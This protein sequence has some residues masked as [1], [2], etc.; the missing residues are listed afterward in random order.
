MPQAGLS[1]SFRKLES[2]VAAGELSLT[3][4]LG[5]ARGGTTAFEKHIFRQLSFDANVNEPSLLGRPP[6]EAASEAPPAWSSRE[7]ATFAQVLDTV[8]P[9]DAAARRQGRDLVRAPVR[10]IVKEVTNKVLPDM[11]PLWCRLAHT[12]L[13]V[14]RNPSLQ[15]ESRLKSIV[16][17]IGSGALAQWGVTGDL[18][19]GDH[20]E[21]LVH[22]EHLILPRPPN[23]EDG[24][25]AAP[26]AT[27]FDEV[28][29]RMCKTR[30]FSR[31]GPGL[32]RVSALHPFCEWRECQAAMW[33]TSACVQQDP[34]AAS[35]V[36]AALGTELHDFAGLDLR[37]AHGFLEW[38]L[39]WTPLQAQ[40]PLLA[41]HPSVHVVDFSVFQENPDFFV[42]TLRGLVAP[43]WGD[44]VDAPRI[45]A[46]A[47]ADDASFAV[48]STAKQ[49]DQKAWDAWYGTPCFGKVSTT[50]GVEPAKKTP[51]GMPAMPPCTTEAVAGAY[52]QYVDLAMDPRAVFP[53]AAASPR[54]PST[55][56]PLH[57]MLWH[58]LRGG[59][60]SELLKAVKDFTA[61]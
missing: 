12:V 40:L 3:F 58:E 60:R 61:C 9:L 59:A 55:V 26:G 41:H 14:V 48:C 1:P 5:L 6:A 8:L 22:G 24:G 27:T 32:V 17:R 45:Q 31:L 13:V 21:L 51:I 20:G 33:E 19:L 2:L 34:G 47:N 36:P 11:V 10:V 28:W 23:A 57:E 15:V 4:V 44:D 43:H 35:L 56:D 25:A 50:D 46:D 39:G 16:D 53:C 29:A 7:E 52:R 30:D 18:P 49:W 54:K 37:L 38:R 42:D